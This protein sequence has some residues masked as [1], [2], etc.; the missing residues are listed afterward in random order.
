VLPA[1]PKQ[2]EE[3]FYLPTAKYGLSLVT[4]VTMNR[5]KGTPT[6]A[7]NRNKGTPTTAVIMSNE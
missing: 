7:L 6:T 4:F 1:L 3:G 2:D 5:N